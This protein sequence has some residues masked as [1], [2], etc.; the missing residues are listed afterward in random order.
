MS[1]DVGAIMLPGTPIAPDSIDEIKS[2]FDIEIEIHCRRCASHKG[3]F[4]SVQGRPSGLF[5]GAASNVAMSIAV[6]MI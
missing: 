3:P 1:Q 5:W 4:Q 6:D 2:V